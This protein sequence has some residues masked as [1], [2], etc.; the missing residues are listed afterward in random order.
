[1]KFNR[2]GYFQLTCSIGSQKFSIKE[3]L[4]NPLNNM[5]HFTSVFKEVN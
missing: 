4:E 3:K 5:S 1:M 2:S